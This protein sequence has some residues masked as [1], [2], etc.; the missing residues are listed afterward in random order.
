MKRGWLLILAIS[1][2]PARGLAATTVELLG[3][4]DQH[5]EQVELSL[6]GL[7]RDFGERRGL[8]GA[9]EAEKR[10]EEAVLAFLLEDYPRS[11]RN[12]FTLVESGALGN[13]LLQG[14]AEWY[15]GESMYYVGNY[16][17]ASES[18]DRIIS[19]D[20]H[21][22]FEDAVRRQ[23]EVFGITQDSDNFYRVFNRFIL[24]NK[25]EPSDPVRYTLGKS[26]YRQ[27]DMLRSK[28]MFTD[29][30][31]ASDLY[32]K[33]QF[34]L[35]VV[36]VSEGNLAAATDVFLNAAEASQEGEGDL[37]EVNELANLS[38]ARLYYEQ[39]DLPT[40]TE[41]YQLI[42]S[43]SPYFADAL[44]ETVWTFVKM[45]N[46]AEALRS[47]EIFLL[48]YQ[49]EHR[50][51]AQ[52]KLLRGQLHMKLAQFESALNTFEQVVSE[53]TPI[54]HELENIYRDA[55]LPSEW[56]ER[57]TV[58]ESSEEIATDT[59]P[60]YTVEMLLSDERYG[61]IV[62]AR[63]ALESQETDVDI[64][65]QLIRELDEALAAS[66]VLGTYHRG[67][68]QRV[69]LFNEFLRVEHDLLE[70]QEA[71]MLDNADADNLGRLGQ[72]Q[73]Q[74]EQLLERTKALKEATS[75]DANNTSSDPRLE[76]LQ[77]EMIRL[78]SELAE[79]TVLI[80]DQRFKDIASRLE[81]SE[82][83]EADRAR[84]ERDLADLGTETEQIQA[85]LTAA[86]EEKVALLAV[87]STEAMRQ[88][89]GQGEER[90]DLLASFKALRALH[91]RLL[92]QMSRLDIDGS[93][94]GFQSTW[95]RIDLIGT[96][97]VALE[98]SMEG[99]EQSELA[100]VRQRLGLERTT[101]NEV[102]R[103]LVAGSTTADSLGVGITREQFREIEQAF[104]DSVL[105]ADMGIVDVFWTR[106]VHAGDDREELVQEQQELLRSLNTR[107]QDVGR[108]LE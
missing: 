31:R 107:F 15:L 23:L 108:G 59:V 26:F 24:T 65:E 90:E 60:V 51:A 4:I 66:E 40:S 50:Y 37:Q 34:F 3:E 13:D 99:S 10:F 2:A 55:S 17:L 52:L 56:F 45:E 88:T 32:S 38:L 64:S 102:R 78:Q 62:D 95:Q 73:T 8:L 9:G 63:R 21:P 61:R 16:V 79:V 49:D 43:S 89:E 28:S 93:L 25:V 100:V 6:L 35:G 29:I 75:P 19:D 11:A 58:M 94:L 101:V 47:V 83:D 92:A 30:T 41:Y 57:L 72:F 14:D 42:D 7:E 36:H 70:V 53:Y 22:F 76:R 71:W 27:G 80:Q 104:E 91:G 12:F 54:Q 86:Q 103:D 20:E 74:R 1:A 44:Y 33:A 81:D 84:G 46:F 105:K 5:V 68:L 69:H 85:R 39:G 98:G 67:R 97:L 87:A 48:A 82:V 96:R 18:Y 77:A 106:K